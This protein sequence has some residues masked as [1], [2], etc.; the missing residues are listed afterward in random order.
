MQPVQTLTV[1]GGAVDVGAHVLDV[2]VPATLGAA[3][4][5]RHRHAPRRALATH[6]TFRCH[7]S[8]LRAAGNP[9]S[10]TFPGSLFDPWS[11]DED[12][13]CRDSHEM[14]QVDGSAPRNV[15]GDRRPLRR[16]SALGNRRMRRRGVRLLRRLVSSST[17][18]TLER[19]NTAALPASPS[20]LSATPSAT[21]CRAEPAQRLSRARRRHRDEHDPHGGVGGRR[22]PACREHGAGGHGH[23]PRFAHGRPG[24]QRH[25][26]L[27]DPPWDRRCLSQRAERRS[28]PDRRC[29]RPCLD[30]RLQGGGQAGGRHHPHRPAA[31]RPERPPRPTRLSARISPSSSSGCTS[32]PRSRS[33]RP[34][35]CSPS[36]RRQAWST[37][38]VP[39]SSS[40]WQPFSR[41]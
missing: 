37:P 2:R 40:C 21:T 38:G 11:P 30:G 17:V 7:W 28:R 14:Y 6:F 33:L 9:G 8:L 35:S 20:E 4:G 41:R 26:P 16:T 36:S 5:V 19:L 29:P 32:A 23:R 25:H 39:A 22:P 34:P 27:P 12:S 31:R 15:V 10:I 24:K 18:P 1:V 3:V 13:A